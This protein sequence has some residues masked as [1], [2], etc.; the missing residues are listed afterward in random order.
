MKRLQRKENMNITPVTQE[1]TEQMNSFSDTSL[2]GMSLSNA[3]PSQSLNNVQQVDRADDKD[4]IEPRTEMSQGYPLKPKERQSQT[5]GENQTPGETQTPENRTQG[6]NQTE[7]ERLNTENEQYKSSLDYINGLIFGGSQNNVSYQDMLRLQSIANNLG[8][9]MS[10]ITD[11]ASQ[12]AFISQLKNELYRRI[13]ANNDSIY[14]ITYNSDYDPRNYDE[15]RQDTAVSRMTEDYVRAGLNPAGVSG[16]SGFGGGGSGGQSSKDEDEREKRKRKRK[17]ELE[18]Q[19]QIEQA[20][21]NEVFRIIAMLGGLGGLG[22]N[23]GIRTATQMNRNNTYRDRLDFDISRHNE[24]KN[25]NNNKRD[26]KKPDWLDDY[27]K[28]L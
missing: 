8:L 23:A 1:A 14:N 3:K 11:E 24:Y 18:R 7:L 26:V 2:N 22:L 28:T 25:F 16:S 12:R 15:I 27:I 9:E 5:P 19:R 6:Q 4:P 13:S 17:E 20:K 21:R 10:N